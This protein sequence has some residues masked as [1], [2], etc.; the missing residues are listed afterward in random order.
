MQKAC[1]W[2]HVTYAQPW[3]HYSAAHSSQ[4]TQESLLSSCSAY[5][6]DTQIMLDLILLGQHASFDQLEVDWHIEDGCGTVS[7]IFLETPLRLGLAITSCIMK[8]NMCADT[9]LKLKGLA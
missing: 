5:L 3:S 2:Y 7:F 4:V 1:A 9:Q 6:L 8:H